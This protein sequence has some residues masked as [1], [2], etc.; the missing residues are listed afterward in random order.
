MFTFALFHTS[1]ASHIDKTSWLV[2]VSVTTTSGRSHGDNQHLTPHASPV[3]VSDENDD[4][5]TMY[6]PLHCHIVFRERPS[7][8]GRKHPLLS[9]SHKWKTVKCRNG[10]HSVVWLWF[11]FLTMAKLALNLTTCIFSLFRTFAFMNHICGYHFALCGK[12]IPSETL[13]NMWHT[14]FNVMYSFIQGQWHHRFS[15]SVILWAVSFS[16]QLFM[17]MYHLRLMI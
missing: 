3:G 7:S 1:P 2:G 4:V 16:L 14:K 5:Q 9:F 11:C 6:L 12:F 15:L 8:A 10:I 13:K 17:S